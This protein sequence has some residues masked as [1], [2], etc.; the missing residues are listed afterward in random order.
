MTIHVLL[1]LLLLQQQQ[2]STA[3]NLLRGPVDPKVE[4]GHRSTRNAWREQHDTGCLQS[5]RKE[6]Q[7]WRKK[8]I[9]VANDAAER[10]G[11]LVIEMAD[12]EEQRVSN[13]LLDKDA[14]TLDKR[15][16]DIQHA[17]DQKIS[18]LDTDCLANHQQV[19]PPLPTSD[20]IDAHTTTLRDNAEEDSAKARAQHDQNMDRAVKLAQNKK[21]YILIDSDNQKRQA[22][23][24]VLRDCSTY[25]N[26]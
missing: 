19:S 17:T 26:V 11:Q 5:T 10:A 1:L 2:Q 21:S 15:L 22:K 4:C 20:C 6:N 9:Q 16:E 24:L 18:Q 12:A 13:E 25:V 23:E 8:C 3:E 7:E 14:R